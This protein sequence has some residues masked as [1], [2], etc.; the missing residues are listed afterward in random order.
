M[1][2]KLGKFLKAKEVA[3]LLGVSESWVY[4]NT[5]LLG[6]VKLKGSLRFFENK[7]VEVLEN[8]DAHNV[9]LTT[10]QAVLRHKNATTTAI[11]LHE[12]RGVKV[13]LD[14]I[15]GSQ[16]QEAGKQDFAF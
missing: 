11:Y 3:E 2:K 8:L 16:E 1:L 9:P 12:L 14:E 7:I 5:D 4:A 13:A 10:I 15:F 6:D